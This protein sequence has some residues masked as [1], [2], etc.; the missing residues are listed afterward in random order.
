[1][2]YDCAIKGENISKKFK[3][4]TLDIP[5]FKVPKGFATALIG[6]NGAGKTTLLNMLSGIRLDYKGKLTFFD[7]YSSEEKERKFDVKNRI[8]YTGTGRYYLPQW[9]VSDVEE[10]SSLLFDN[11]DRDEFRRYCRELA[12]FPDFPDGFAPKKK[13]SALSDGTRTKL[14]LAG[15]MA[16]D[17]D[18][19]LLDEPASPLDPLMRDKL[20]QMIGDYINDGAGERSVLFS[21]HNI[22]DMESITDYAIIMEHGNVVECGFVEDLKEKYILIKGDAQDVDAASKILYTMT[23]NPYGFE[24]I[25]LAENLDKLAGMNVSK[26]IPSLFQISVAVMKN[27]TRLVMR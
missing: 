24:G 4:F 25:C 1:M 5:E 15:V 16:R 6:E 10:I 9:T 22:S 26:E 8:G 19:L 18:L 21:T 14:M 17:T 11:F 20:C 23:K 2:N 12:I 7:K 13:C 3:T 27:N